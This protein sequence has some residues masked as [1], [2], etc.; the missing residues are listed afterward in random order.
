MSTFSCA[1]SLGKDDMMRIEEVVLLELEGISKTIYEYTT[2]NYIRSY[3]KQLERINY[4]TDKNKLVLLVDRL[5]EWYSKN[6]NQIIDGEF[7]LNKEGHKKGYNL[8]LDMQRELSG[9]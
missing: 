8:L 6:I 5:C 7:T 4:P 1:I 3:T 9:T 2:D